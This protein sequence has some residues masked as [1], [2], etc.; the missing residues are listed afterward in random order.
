MIYRVYVF[1]E[2][3]GKIDHT[4]RHC[5]VFQRNIKSWLFLSVS[6]ATME[7]IPW[8]CVILWCFVATCFFFNTGHQYS[9]TH[10]RWESSYIGFHG[11]FDSYAI[12]AILVTMNTFAAHILALVALP[13]IIFWPQISGQLVFR[14]TMSRQKP[15]T[16]GEMVLSEDST[17]LRTCVFSVIIISMFYYSFK[18]RSKIA[19]VF[20][21][22]QLIEAEWCIYAS[23]N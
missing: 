23:V 14:Y 15:D 10:I 8:S 20:G 17:Q 7:D 4:I 3:L 2:D 18:V 1:C 5:T 11:N 21:M 16:R 9:V 13:L 19:T 12:P 6:V 22:P